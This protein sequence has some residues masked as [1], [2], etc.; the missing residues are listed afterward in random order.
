MSL[1]GL[2]SQWSEKVNIIIPQ[3]LVDLVVEHFRLIFTSEIEMGGFR[4][5]TSSLLLSLLFPY[6]SP[7]FLHS[8]VPLRSV[9]TEA[10]SS[11]S[12]V[13]GLKLTKWFLFC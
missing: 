8:S 3:V 11:T 4:T 6:N 9:V 7:L 10:G 1:S 12:I 5:G 13:A 2:K